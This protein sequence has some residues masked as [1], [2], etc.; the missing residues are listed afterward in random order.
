MA[1]KVEIKFTSPGASRVVKDFDK[2]S[3]KEQE[4]IL[5][6]SKVGKALKKAG[7]DA[8]RG[9]K[10]GGMSFD[11]LKNRIRGSVDVVE[12]LS[13]AFR[14]AQ[15][16]F[17]EFERRQ[18]AAAGKQISVEGAIG[19][20]L[21][22]NAQ[23]AQ[24][25]P[26]LL[27]TVKK[28]ATKEG[29]DLGPGGIADVIQA[30]TEVRSKAGE[31]FTLDQQLGAV[32][33]AVTAKLIDRDVNLSSIASANLRTQKALGINQ[34]KA[35][36]VLTAFGPKAGGDVNAFVGEF[37]GLQGQTSAIRTIEKKQFGQAKTDFADLLALTGIISQAL[38]ESPE[39]T[40]TIVK[41]LTS[42]VGGARVGDKQLSFK[43]E[44]TIERILELADRVIGGEFG[45]GKERQQ[46]LTSA[47]LK[48]AK[49]LSTLAA[50]IENENLLQTAR[51]DIREAGQ[52][53][54]SI[55]DRTLGL[56]SQ[57]R[58]NQIQSGAIK[59]AA[60]SAQISNVGAGQRQSAIENIDAISESF[61]FT[62]DARAAL[63]VDKLLL[64]LG[65]RDPESVQK[66]AIGGA[67]ILATD[68]EKVILQGMLDALNNIDTRL[69][70][71]KTNDTGGQ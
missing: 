51:T 35:Q 55:Q 32:K 71:D 48:G 6:G 58:R 31:G 42:K 49:G 22:N 62:S 57:T 44:G 3:K 47:G 69:G 52:S 60:E 26:Q 17:E 28:F 63:V 50:L 38:G 24:R 40:S 16:D 27:A 70:Q 10:K 21:L 54:F 30:I 56:I 46:V 68:D 4:I 67:K 66:T 1:K 45:T 61:A 14:V 11:S 2:L 59:G 36:N 20:F 33:E 37:G 13:K 5:Q 18:Q 15:K 29:A 19:N 25:D 39:N 12:L 41:S 34:T 53:G 43:S 65:L 7:D 9:A 64:R 8:A 23:A